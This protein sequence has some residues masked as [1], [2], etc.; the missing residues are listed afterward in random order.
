MLFQAIGLLN[1]ARNGMQY[2]KF[3]GYATKIYFVKVCSIFYEVGNKG[4]AI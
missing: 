4:Y 3:V 2:N 1:M